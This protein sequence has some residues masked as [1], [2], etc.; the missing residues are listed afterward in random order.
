[1][2]YEVDNAIIMAAGLSSRFA[3]LSYEQPKALISVKGEI[4]IER[5]IRQLHEVGITDIIIVVGYKKEQFYYL[6]EKFN[7]KIIENP[8]YEIRNNNSSIYAVRKYLKNSYICSADN[9]FPT[10]PFEKM[11][12]ESYYSAIFSDG[13]TNE[14]CLT[15]DDSDWITDVTIGGAN[16]WFMLGHVFW[17]EEF[18]QKFVSILEKIY[19]EPSTADKLWESIYIDYIHLL[20]MKIRKYDSSQI[21]EF[22]TLDELRQ[23]DSTYYNDT[24]SRIIRECAKQIGCKENDLFHFEPLKNSLGQ[25]I[26]VSFKY[27]NDTY[28]YDYS[29]HLLEKSTSGV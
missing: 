22:D 27:N 16:Q 28:Q 14:W 18:S 3:P 15:Y 19:D 23:F 11:V 5:Q 1:M 13:P 9:Y 10:N 29:S 17:S 7:V 4:L 21:F 12:D 2:K 20:K 25:V 8:E 24:R 26:G 6:E